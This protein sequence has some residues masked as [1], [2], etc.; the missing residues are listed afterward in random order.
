MNDTVIQKESQKDAC[1]ESRGRLK[2]SFILS[3]FFPWYEARYC[4]AFTSSTA[5]GAER[6]RSIG[7]R[8]IHVL[9]KYWFQEKKSNLRGFLG[10]NSYSKH[11]FRRPTNLANIFSG[12]FCERTLNFLFEPWDSWCHE[13]IIA[14]G[15]YPN[16]QNKYP[17]TLEI[18]A[19]RAGP[20]WFLIKS[21]KLVFHFK[22]QL[23]LIFSTFELYLIG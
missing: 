6:N 16:T 17:N 9:R 13:I 18:S 4:K 21:L 3:E 15:K 1:F 22:Y 8:N 23:V 20:S 5:A 11:F 10:T 2:K 12:H 14:F 7:S 19:L